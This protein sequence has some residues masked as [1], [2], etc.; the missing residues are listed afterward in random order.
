[1]G[2][3]K[4]QSFEK[5]RETYYNETTGSLDFDSFLDD[6]FAEYT[7]ED[8]IP[9][10]EAI[11]RETSVVKV[12]ST[13][14]ENL[15][16]STEY[17]ASTGVETGDKSQAVDITTRRVLKQLP[18]INI[19]RED[20]RG[21]ELAFVLL[22]A[23][24]RLNILPEEETFLR[25]KLTTRFGELPFDQLSREMGKPLNI[26]RHV[27]MEEMGVVL[28]YVRDIFNQYISSTQA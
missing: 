12:G 24:V 26:Q 6:T 27:N 5:P 15:K 21:N 2:D 13:E 28:G 25:R 7:V 10:M 9:A 14:E 1:M 4:D 11:E 20:P 8:L 23:T 22:F 16:S 17:Q 3:L 18:A 19:S